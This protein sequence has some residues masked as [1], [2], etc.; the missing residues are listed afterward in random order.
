MKQEFQAQIDKYVLRQMDEAEMSAFEQD[1]AV[2][3][4]IQEQLQ[5]TQEVASATRSR[6]EKL[7]KMQEWEDDYEWKDER[8][9]AAARYRPTGSGY[10]SCPA[11]SMEQTR[12]M[13]R[14]SARQYLYWIS[15]IAAIFIVGFFLIYNFMGS[16][17]NVMFDP[18]SI[19]Y[20]VMRGGE[21]YANIEKL[22][23]DKKYEDALKQIEIEETEIIEQ[24]TAT[25]SISDVERRAYD[26][27]LIQE[28]TDELSWMKVYALL[29]VDRRDDALRL[30]DQLRQSEG[31]YKSK[32]DS[33]YLLINK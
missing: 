2:D 9:V 15:G 28:K 16:E 3:A 19:E 13:P 1:V 4:E 31:E 18:S 23:V 30:L 22:L 6:E 26:Q 20:R 12:A 7:A 32:A 11:P 5:F 10:E 29:G 25:D 14:S 8:N 33:L 21:N 17:D 27:M 24:R